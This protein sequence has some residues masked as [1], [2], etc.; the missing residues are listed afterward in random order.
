MKR[1]F[2]LI[3]LLV[4]IAII[5]IL[6]AILFPVFAQAKDSAKNTQLLSQTKQLGTANI[7]YSTD[8]DDMF[9]PTMLSSQLY[10]I[11]DAWQ[12]LIQPY[13]HN[14]EMIHNPKREPFNNNYLTRWEHFGMPARA[15][16]NSNATIQTNKYFSGVHDGIPI[17]YDGIGGLGNLDPTMGDWLNRIPGPSY[18]TTQIQNPSITMMLAESNWWDQGMSIIYW[19]TDPAEGWCVGNDA[20]NGWGIEGVT[21]TTKPTNS[22]S[23]GVN[24][25]GCWWQDGRSTMVSCDSSA[26]SLAWRSNFYAPAPGNDASFQIIKTM[27]PNGW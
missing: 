15:A 16:I 1:A 7:M 4:V 13:V 14:M 23:S 25:A 21:C 9:A 11:D 10:M 22:Y 19:T 2:T 5:A 18:T 27:N 26:R 8:Y 6:A 12:W 3:E 20:L 24:G 17:R